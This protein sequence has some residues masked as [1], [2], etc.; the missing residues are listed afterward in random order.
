[1]AEGGDPVGPAPPP[2][3]ASLAAE[4]ARLGLAP[5]SVVFVHS[6]LRSLG[7]VCGG[8]VAVVQALIDA[9]GPSGTIVVPT[10]TPEHSD[11]ASWIHPPVPEPWWPVIRAETPAFDPRLTPSHGMGVIAETVRTWP[12]ARRSGHPAVSCAA[13]GAEAAEL[14][15]P[16]PLDFGLGDESPVG[17]L[18]RR[19][20]LVLLLGVGYDRATALHLAQYQ[21]PGRVEVAAGAPVLEDGRR[22]WREYRE[23]DFDTEPFE[24]IGLAFERAGRVRVG[25]VGRTTARLFS[26]GEAVDFAVD[27]LGGRAAG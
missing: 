5:G 14:T 26:L 6:S 23:I 10:H 4:L 18:Y 9:V 15:R 8:P 25:P 17:R 7:W 22:V 1:M 16:H 19:G 13:L 24:S 11:P 21:L 20:A 3:R 27:W 2:T 12:G